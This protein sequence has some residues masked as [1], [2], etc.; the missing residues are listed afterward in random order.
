[1]NFQS[2]Q[3]WLEHSTEDYFR[4]DLQELGMSDA[5]LDFLCPVPNKPA[6]LPPQSWFWIDREFFKRADRKIPAELAELVGGFFCDWTF[7]KQVRFLDIPSV[8]FNGLPHPGLT[9]VNAK[10]SLNGRWV[11]TEVYG[12]HCLQETRGGAGLLGTFP[13]YPLEPVFKEL[14]GRS[15]SQRRDRSW[16][17]SFD[18]EQRADMA[19]ALEH[20]LD[21]IPAVFERHWDY[22]SA[23]DKSHRDLAE[24]ILE[25]EIYV[26]LAGKAPIQTYFDHGWQLAGTG[27]RL[28]TLDLSL[29]REEGGIGYFEVKYNDRLRGRQGQWICS[30][31]RPLHLEYGVIKLRPS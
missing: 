24:R 11:S 5:L 7:Q 26:D 12:L 28:G 2:T 30:V 6:I 22:I 3:P 16:T 25:L 9:G 14:F 1:M 18:M 29:A 27:C 19:E 31:G 21:N 10:W 8:E 15:C 20:I 23:L 17:R 13:Y 4:E